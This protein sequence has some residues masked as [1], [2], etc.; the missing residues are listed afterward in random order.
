[1]RR[2]ARRDL[3]E[4]KIVEALEAIGCKVYRSLPADLLVH[5]SAWGAGWFRV[6]ECKTPHGKAG[7]AV[8]DKRQKDQILFLEQTGTPRVTTPE[9]ALEAVTQSVTKT[10]TSTGG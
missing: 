8:V 7:K 4:P 5:R 3:S 1:M 10:P 2:A 9:A 6:L